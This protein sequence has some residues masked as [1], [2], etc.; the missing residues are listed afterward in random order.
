MSLPFLFV[1]LVGASYRLTR[2]VTNDDIPPLAW[3]R[4][5]FEIRVRVK[6]GEEWASGVRCPF[7]AGWWITAI[8]TAWTDWYVG[9]PL[10][11]LWFLAAAGAVGLIGKHLDP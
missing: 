3:L 2:I 11:I 7:C 6:W 1:L 4:E 10:P 5:E 8:T 9:L